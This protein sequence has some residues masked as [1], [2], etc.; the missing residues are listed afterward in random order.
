LFSASGDLFFTDQGQSGLHDASGRMFR[1]DAAGKLT[2]RDGTQLFVAVPRGNAVWRL[3]SMED[4]TATK[5][6]LF[7]QMSGGIA[8]PDG[9]ALDQRVV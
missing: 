3:P 1:L 2:L 4:G 6:G 5:V 8:G 9:L 7:I